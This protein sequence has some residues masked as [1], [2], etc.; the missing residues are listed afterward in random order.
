MKECFVKILKSTKNCATYIFLTDLIFHSNRNNRS[1]SR[2]LN[3]FCFKRAR[4]TKV[5]NFLNFA[6]FKNAFFDYFQK[7]RE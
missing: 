7:R 1:Q 2:T 4:S 3:F 5:E 6:F